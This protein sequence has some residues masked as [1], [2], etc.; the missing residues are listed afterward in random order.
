MNLAAYEK[1]KRAEYAAFSQTVASILVAAV[2]A[3]AALRLQQVQHRAK[4]PASLK[5]KL[6]DRG[7][8]DCPSIE[9]EIKDLAGCR[10]IFYTNS[11]VTRFLGSGIITKNFKVDWDR[12]KIHY[13]AA[14]AVN[15]DDLFISHNYVVAISESRETL[16]RRIVGVFEASTSPPK[17]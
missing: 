4:D 1:E 17:E 8:L 11:D 14:D 12:T 15:P 9:T 13:P 10:L 2:G 16:R 5:K 3:D 6:E 7:I